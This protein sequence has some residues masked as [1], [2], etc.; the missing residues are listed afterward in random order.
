MRLDDDFDDFEDRKSY[1][2]KRSADMPA[3][4]VK[5]AGIVSVFAVVAILILVVAANGKNGKKQPVSSV[6]SQE[7]TE[8]EKAA[9]EQAAL[10]K[11]VDELIS[12][13]TL[14]AEDLD[15]W[16]TPEKP[17]QD[18]KEEEKDDK[19]EAETTETEEED[20]AT[21]GKHTLLTYADG[22]EEWVEINPYLKKN[23]YN[24]AGFVLKNG[25]LSY[26]ENNGKISTIGVDI[27]KSQDYVDFYE[28]KKSGIDFVMIALGGRGYASGE[29]YLDE[30]FADNIKRATEAGLDVGV[31][32]F[33]TAITQ[34]EAIEEAHFVSENLVPYEVKYP[35]AYYTEAVS[36]QESRSDSLNKMTRTLI[37]QAFMDTIKECGYSTVLYGTKEWLI[38]KYSLG[39]FSGTDMWLSQNGNLPDYPYQFIMWRYTTTGHV[40]GIAGPANINICFVDYSKK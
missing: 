10:E 6:S 2:N 19:D 16:D 27:S 15:I 13:S 31:Y 36:R 38:K 29:L 3:G 28:I 37:S 9:L 33:S 35:V 22:S 21:D 17:E 40:P 34:E 18:T 8:A 7:M 11:S 39:S 32:F 12:G 25:Y 5:T 14:R 24:N 26:Y 4:N 20:P 23:D 30:Y 1:K